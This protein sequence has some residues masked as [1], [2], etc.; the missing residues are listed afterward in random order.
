[1]PELLALLAAA[2]FA[3][4]TTLQQRGALETAAGS[5]DPRFLVQVIHRPAWLFGGLFQMVGWILQ[6]AALDHGQLEVVQAII[7]LSLVMALPLGARLTSQVVGRRQVAGAVLTVGGIVLFLAAGSPEGGTAHPSAAAWWVAGLI[8]GAA[9]V[10]LGGL[11]W[12][13]RGP[14]GAIL[15]AAGAGVCFAF[16]AAVTKEFVSQLGH[17]VATVLTSWTPYV[18]LVTALIGF[19]LQQ[20]ALKK[21]QLAPAM[22][23]SNSMTLLAS[24]IIGSA[25]FGETIS[26]GGGLPVA[27]LGLVMAVAGIWALAVGPEPAGDSVRPLPVRHPG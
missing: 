11:G 26:Q 19:A 16:Q 7:T 17:G 2:S 20:T 23:S 6:A 13:R 25:V 15:L 21:G 22:A 14:V 12:A 9:V 18:L 27:V 4:G 10:V 5:E 8:S 24:V 3:L 1:M